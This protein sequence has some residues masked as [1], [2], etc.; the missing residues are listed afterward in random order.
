MNNHL[1]RVNQNA[2]NIRIHVSSFLCSIVYVNYYRLM[3]VKIGQKNIFFGKPKLIKVGESNIE[4]G[5]N[6]RF[7]SDSFSN[8]IGINH[9]CIIVTHLSSANLKI[10]N[11][12]G[13]S[14]TT[15][16]CFHEIEIGNNVRCGA[17]TMI[18]DSDWHLDDERLGGGAKSVVIEDNVWLGY[19]VV[20]MKGVCIGANTIIGAGSVVVSDI[21][22][23][24]IA[25]GNPCKVI[26]PLNI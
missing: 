16:G 10:G 2:R 7:R 20:V 5:N 24:V 21:P 4:I 25:A 12:C 15:I 26:K 1:N 6:C 11:S 23:N 19:G 14:G 18:T 3:G 22:A 13:F 8:L 17:N 9:P